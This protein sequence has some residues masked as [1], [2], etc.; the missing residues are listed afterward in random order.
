[1]FNKLLTAL[2]F[3]V[4]T[5][6]LVGCKQSNTPIN[7]K[8]KKSKFSYFADKHFDDLDNA[9][10]EISNQ[11]LLNIDSNSHKNN[12]IVVT[13]FVSLDEFT[14]T[15]S[16]GRMVGESLI[17]ELHS[18]KFKLIDFRASEAMTVNQNGEFTLSRDIDKLKD[19]MP[20]A[21]VLVGTYSLL[22]TKRLVLNAR[23]VNNF[24]SDVLS[25][26]RVVYEFED[27]KRFDLCPKIMPKKKPEPK[28]SK[29][30]V[31]M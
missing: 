22:D 1:M 15:S 14:K 19:E 6:S 10:M 23:I 8:Y 31:D 21:F 3:T 26:A 27:C 25:T 18:R 2:L 4:I 13:S 24:T 30:L 16:F 5:V 28:K 29:I 17:N 7:N 9:I 12:K 11:L 20:E